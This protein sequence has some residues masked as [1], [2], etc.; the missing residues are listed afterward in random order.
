[1]TTAAKMNLNLTAKKENTN[2]TNDLEK[3]TSSK[4][5]FDLKQRY[6]FNIIARKLLTSLHLYTNHIFN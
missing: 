2:N 1:M 3:E 5:K 6:S 4:K